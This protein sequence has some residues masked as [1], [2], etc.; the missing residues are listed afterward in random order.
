MNLFNADSRRRRGI[1]SAMAMLF[2]VLFATLSLGFYASVTTSVQVAK[3]DRRNARALLAAESG[4][5]FMRYH[6]ANV[7]I[8]PTSADPMGELCANLKAALE[9]TGNLGGNSVLLNNNTIT[10]PSQAGSYIKTDPADDSGFSAVITNHGGNIVCTVIGRTGLDYTKVATKGVSLDFKR[11]IIP[12]SVFDYAV[13]AK[14]GVL[15]NKGTL[16]GVTGV[17]SNSIATLM[18]AKDVS[19]ALKASGGTVGGDLNVVTNLNRASVSGANVAGTNNV[20]MI[21]S[22]H[23]HLVGPP[24]FP[25]FDT[26]V[27][28]QYATNTYTGAKQGTLAN[29]TIPPNTNPTF[30]G[31]VAVQ[32]I[33]YIQSPNTV[34]F[35]GDTKLQGFIVFENAGTVDQNVISMTGNFSEGS[36]PQG[37][38]FDSLRTITGISVLA[39]TASLTMTGSVDSQVRGNMILGTFNNSGAANVQFDQGSLLTLDTTNT[40]STSINTSKSMKWSATGKNNQPSVGVEYDTKFI[41]VGGSYRELN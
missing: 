20:S 13:A 3:N 4:V 36:L 41:P 14:G 7:V 34:T 9:G 19:A 17:S 18:S 23:T 16:S 25:V 38:Q 26:S 24:Q 2:L 10:I 40:N 39:P 37:S 6:L 15:M 32:G 11:Q 30:T 8:S 33:L 29:I 31:N 27:F 5:Q 1:T 21:Y 22:Q 35:Q 28:A 12:T